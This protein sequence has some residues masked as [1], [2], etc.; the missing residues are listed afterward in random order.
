MIKSFTDLM[1]DIKTHEEIPDIL[2][3]GLATNSNKVKN[4]YLFFA[5]KGENFDGNNFIKSAFKN[6]AY[7]VITEKKVS[8]K[9][10]NKLIIHVEDIKK[11]ISAVANQ[12]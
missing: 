4:G 1:V 3:Y 10:R 7:A 6:G 11:T 5:V 8:S 9:Q 12:F 2:I